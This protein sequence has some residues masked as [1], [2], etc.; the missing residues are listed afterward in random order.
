MR[1]KRTGDAADLAAQIQ[2]SHQKV[3]RAVVAKIWELSDGGL[4]IFEVAAQTNYPVFLVR[5]VLRGGPPSGV[6]KR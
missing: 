4:D 5:C 6:S 1:Q 3:H 2:L